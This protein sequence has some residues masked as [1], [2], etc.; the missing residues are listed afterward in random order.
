MA[1][2][3]NV[4]IDGT[5]MKSIILEKYPSLIRLAAEIGYSSNAFSSA[6]KKGRMT[7]YMWKAASDK[8]GITLEDVQP[9]PEP[10]PEPEP[11]PVPEV[12]EVSVP[13]P[14]L[15]PNDVE[16]KRF[17]FFNDEELEILNMFKGKVDEVIELLKQQR[18]TV[19][20]ETLA[21]G[22]NW[23]MEMFWSNHKKEIQDL[24][25]KNIKGAVFSGNLEALKKHDELLDE[26]YPYREYIMPVENGR[27][28]R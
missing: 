4:I 11:V 6:F 15:D 23:G 14:V 19:N 5:K 24:I 12:P 8:L 21:Q 28:E 3:A 1:R 20:E 2:V 26:R 10:E 22:F 25:V 17:S 7:L 27:P 16:S 18:K 9:D 13:D